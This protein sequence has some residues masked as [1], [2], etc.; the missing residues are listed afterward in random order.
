MEMFCLP[1]G[2]VPARL[3]L[4]FLKETGFDFSERRD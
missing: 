3:G 4:P 1:G 2:E